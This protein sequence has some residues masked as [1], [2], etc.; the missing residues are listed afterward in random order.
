MAMK[1]KSACVATGCVVHQGERI[2]L[3][4]R[5]ISDLTFLRLPAP[6]LGCNRDKVG[7]SI[8]VA[9]VVWNAPARGEVIKRVASAH[10]AVTDG[11]L[12]PV[13]TFERWR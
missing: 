12:Y 2:N 6:N 11:T 13:H 5:F 10:S 8:V 3:N 4:S 1:A 9:N 7:P